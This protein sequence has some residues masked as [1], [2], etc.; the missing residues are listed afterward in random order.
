MLAQK[1]Q[2]FTVIGMHKKGV[3]SLGDVL[4]GGIF[5]LFVE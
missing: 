4:V 2:P 1:M 3:Q 5:T